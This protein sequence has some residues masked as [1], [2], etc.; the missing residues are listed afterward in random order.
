MPWQGACYMTK[1]LRR[2]D[3]ARSHGRDSGRFSTSD[4][5][6]A[7]IAYAFQDQPPENMLSPEYGDVATKRGAGQISD[8]E[9]KSLLTA[10]F[11]RIEKLL[12]LRKSEPELYA[13]L[14]VKPPE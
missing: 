12:R 1:H 4:E 10:G 6:N 13:V 5:I 8:E 2:T 7:I 3:R 9:L 14:V 11:Q